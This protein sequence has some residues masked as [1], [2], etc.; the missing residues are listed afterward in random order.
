MKRPLRLALL[1]LLAGW[2]VWGGGIASAQ[3]VGYAGIVVRQADGS[4]TYVYLGFAEEEISGM[5]A[6]QRSGLDVVTVSFGG[7]GLGVCTIDMTG[8]PAAECRR[9]LCQGPNPD[10]PFWKYFRQGDPGVWT[11]AQLGANGSRVRSGDVDGWSWTGTEAKLPALSLREIAERAG[12]DGSGFD[13]NGASTGAVYFREGDALQ[14]DGVPW[15]EYG[16]GGALLLLAAGG[17]AFIALRRA[18][19][20]PA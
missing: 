2:L 19:G 10:D 3:E 15:A 6:L 11:E 4:L 20:A 18:R 14:D 9:R 1:L 17:V 5:E 8:C 7:L 13:A 16:A 12:Y